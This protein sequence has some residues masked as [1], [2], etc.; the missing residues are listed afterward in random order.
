MA[1]T[2][3][4][5]RERSFSASSCI[6]AE[7]K[8]SCAA[9]SADHGLRVTLKAVPLTAFSCRVTSSANACS[10]PSRVNST[11]TWSVFSPYSFIEGS[12]RFLRSVNGVFY[13]RSPIRR[14]TGGKGWVK[15][16]FFP[17]PVEN[18]AARQK[19][20]VFYPPSKD[21]IKNNVYRTAERRV[22]S[23]SA[24]SLSH[25]EVLCR[26]FCERKRENVFRAHAYY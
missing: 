23:R 15:R 3:E 11:S 21:Y 12:F 18:F 7:T 10:L 20:G 25:N 13:C 5:K 19:P 8:A 26:A 17:T 2:Q 4:P 14:E 1:H 6:H 9:S 24:L 22:A 16:R